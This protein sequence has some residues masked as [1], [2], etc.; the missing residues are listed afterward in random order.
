VPIIFSS[1]E[2]ILGA[3]WRFIADPDGYI[4]AIIS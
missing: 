4:S 1:R 3:L 2:N